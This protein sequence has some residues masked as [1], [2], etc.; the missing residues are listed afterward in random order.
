MSRKLHS[1]SPDRITSFTIG[2]L[3]EQGQRI[4]LKQLLNDFENSFQGDSL[5]EGVVQFHAAS[6]GVEVF[7][8]SVEAG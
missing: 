1:S 4:F 5:D 8:D 6:I 2:P 3:A 7:C